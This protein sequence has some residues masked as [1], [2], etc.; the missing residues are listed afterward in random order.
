MVVAL[1]LAAPAAASASSFDP[2]SE[3]ALK[4]W[5]PIHLGALDL[6]INKAVVYLL[7]GSALT[8]LL[9]IGLMRF[10]LSNVPG[11]RQ[12]TGEDQYRPDAGRRDWAADQGWRSGSPTSRRSCSSSAVNL[13]GFRPAVHGSDLP[14]RPR[15]GHLR[16]DLVD[17]RDTRARRDDLGLHPYRGHPFQRARQVRRP[18]SL[19]CPLAHHR[20]RGVLPSS[21]A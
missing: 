7:V 21:C 12:D 4:D 20:D 6:S 19:R 17:L 15:L 13:L 10:R 14:P 8:C 1:A 16:R 5:V 11:R 18:G 9:G 2:S 3:F